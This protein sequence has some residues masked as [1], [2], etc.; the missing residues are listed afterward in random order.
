MYVHGPIGHLALFSLYILYG[1]QSPFI[2]TYAPSK[3]L[4]LYSVCASY[5]ESRSKEYN[6]TKHA[7]RVVERLDHLDN[8]NLLGWLVSWSKGRARS[9]SRYIG[10]YAYAMPQ[11][12]T[13]YRAGGVVVLLVLQCAGYDDGVKIGIQGRAKQRYLFLGGTLLK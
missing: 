9:I 5:G 2:Q 10:S 13:T 11:V 8:L 12:S 1:G 3:Y 7:P 6:C 4:Y